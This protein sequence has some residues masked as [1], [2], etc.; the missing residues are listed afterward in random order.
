[1]FSTVSGDK[2]ELIVGDLQSEDQCQI[3]TKIPG[4]TSYALL[5]SYLFFPRGGCGGE[6]G[7]KE[8]TTIIGILSPSL[9]RSPPLGDTSLEC[10]SVTPYSR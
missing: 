3:K 9:C 8:P 1:M 7:E 4:P 6:L 2:T 5:K 10:H